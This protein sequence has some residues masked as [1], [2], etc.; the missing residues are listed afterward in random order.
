MHLASFCIAKCRKLRRISMNK[1]TVRDVDLSGKR[2]LMRVDFNVPLDGQKVADDTR[3]RAV[4]PTIKYILDQKPKSVALMSHLGRPK[5]KREPEFSL[6]PV[7][8]VLASLLG[9]NVSFVDDCVGEKAEKA[10]ADLPEGGV[11]L[12]ENTRFYAGETKNDA[13]LSPPLAKL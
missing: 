12:L 9:G 2:V 4:V 8:P 13:E 1:K 3:I 7:A 11:L 10:M 5:G 6:A